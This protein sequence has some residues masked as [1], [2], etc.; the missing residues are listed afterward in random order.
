[1][2]KGGRSLNKQKTCNHNWVSYG[3]SWVI[4]HEVSS[5]GGALITYGVLQ[6]CPKCGIQRTYTWTNPAK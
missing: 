4:S 6:F 2:V 1:M 5:K 3:S